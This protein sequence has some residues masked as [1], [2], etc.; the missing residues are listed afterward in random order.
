MS[1]IGEICAL[2]AAASWSFSSL[3][4]FSLQSRLGTLLLNTLR[5]TIA[6][7]FLLI[8]ILIGGIGFDISLEQEILLSL[9]GIIGL[10][11][12]DSFLFLSYKKMGPRISM[13][14]QSSSP[15]MAAILAFLILGEVLSLWAILGI[16]ITLSGISLV[17]I[18]RNGKSNGHEKITRIGFLF[19]MLAALGQAVGL[20][21]AKLAFNS[22][23]I[24]GV[25]ATLMRMLAASIV[26]VPFGIITDKFKATIGNLFNN[27]K[28]A[29]TV[30]LVSFLGSY[31]GVMLSFFAIAYAKVGISSTL[32]STAPILMLPLVHI[33]LKD[34]LSWKSIVG[35][36]IAVSGVAVLFVGR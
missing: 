10:V 2:G 34:H 31:L 13:L 24:N 18:E 3:L 11:L 36:F 17:V 9:S 33:M 15:A 29:G 22:G 23:E 16:I 5:L 32:M 21:F 4:F 35:A 19:A 12:G 8:T 1:Y 6:S 28:T 30:L 14:F 27:K 7:V 26:I 20:I 25:L